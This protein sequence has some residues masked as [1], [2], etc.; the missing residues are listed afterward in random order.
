[1]KGTTYD[2]KDILVSHASNV[3]SVILV[4]PYD[5][6]GAGYRDAWRWIVMHA[7]PIVSYD[8]KNRV[9]IGAHGRSLNGGFWK[10]VTTGD[11]AFVYTLMQWGMEN[12]VKGD[13]LTRHKE[14][15]GEI[16]KKVGGIRVKTEYEFDERNITAIA[17]LDSDIKVKDCE[18]DLS[19]DVDGGSD[20][21]PSDGELGAKQRGRQKGKETFGSVTNIDRFNRLGMRLEEI[22]DSKH[23]E[24]IVETWTWQAMRWVNKEVVTVDGE[25]DEDSHV[26]SA[27]RKS[28]KSAPFVPRDRS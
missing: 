10:Y 14:K 28:A 11:L 3:P 1:M 15:E 24:P 8:W 17:E 16:K 9:D 20:D 13:E 5:R 23:M 2:L 19:D 18:P 6:A 12:W 25:N 22:L 21:E 27:K 26:T 4:T 7:L